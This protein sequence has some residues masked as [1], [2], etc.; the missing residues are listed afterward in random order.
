MSTVIALVAEPASISGAP[1]GGGAKATALNPANRNAKPNSHLAAPQTCLMAGGP[2]ERTVISQADGS[3]GNLEKKNQRK[4][5]SDW[6]DSS[7]THGFPPLPETCP[8]TSNLG[9]PAQVAFF[10]ER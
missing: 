5:G 6:L 1:A 2:F 9:S 8:L 4:S 3:M 7:K 10:A